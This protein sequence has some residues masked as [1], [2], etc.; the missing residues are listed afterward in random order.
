MNPQTISPT[1]TVTGGINMARFSL[2]LL[3]AVLILAHGASGP[4]AQGF[5][6]F[7]FEKN[8]NAPRGWQHR[9]FAHPND[10]KFSIAKFFP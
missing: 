6:G 7:D 1:N 8:P 2:A 9:T 4:L 3:C 10:L 5:R